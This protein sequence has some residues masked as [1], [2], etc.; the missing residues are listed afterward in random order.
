MFYSDEPVE[1]DLAESIQEDMVGIF[2]LNAIRSILITSTTSSQQ[3]PAR[4][5]MIL[6]MQPAI[7]EAFIYMKR[8]RPRKGKPPNHLMEILKV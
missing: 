2:P 6:M 5:I 3:I 7:A 8:K 4:K 1:A